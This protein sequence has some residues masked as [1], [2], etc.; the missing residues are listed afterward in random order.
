MSKQE[1]RC[2]DDDD[3]EQAKK[4]IASKRH[5]SL[6][7]IAGSLEDNQKMLPTRPERV[8]TPMEEELSHV[9][10]TRHQ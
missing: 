4:T 8:D 9:G 6:I 10:E 5:R 2:D 3:N 1:E 7:G